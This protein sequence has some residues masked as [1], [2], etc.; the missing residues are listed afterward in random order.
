MPDRILEALRTSPAEDGGAADPS[1][2]GEG[3]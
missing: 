2:G 3:G 1:S